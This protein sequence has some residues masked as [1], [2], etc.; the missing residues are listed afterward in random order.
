MKGIISSKIAVSVIFAVC[1]GTFTAQA[2][3]LLY[4]G[5]ATTTD[6]QSR[7]AYSTAANTCKLQSDNAKSVAWTKGLA[8]SSPW[9]ETS[10]VL[11]SFPN[12]GLAL[13]AA[14]ADGSGD[15][16]EARGGGFGYCNSGTPDG[17][18]RAK[19]RAITSPMPTTGKLYYRC[20]MKIESAAYNSLKTTS[21]RYMG[22][23]ISSTPAVNAYNNQ[24]NLKNNGIRIGFTSPGASPQRVDI[25]VNIGGQY[26]PV[27]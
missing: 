24:D 1:V 12:K 15:Q 6:S 19:N 14:F 2:D 7:Q 17:E 9:S 20:L 3:L 5:F 4:D 21:W 27:L 18:F 10:A 11:F 13:P 16:F 8:A 23:G 25:G 22:T 26:T